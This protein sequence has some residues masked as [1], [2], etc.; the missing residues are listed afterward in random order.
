MYWTDTGNGTPCQKNGTEDKSFEKTRLSGGRDFNAVCPNCGRTRAILVDAE[1]CCT[2]CGAVLGTESLS[3]EA[4]PFSK[5]NL[6]QMESVGTAKVA[7]ECARHIHEQDRDM[8][9]MS[10]VCVKLDLPMYAAKDAYSTYA[11]VL[12]RTREDRAAF[13][14]SL[15]A[16]PAPPHGSPPATLERPKYFTK[17]H[18]AAFAIH[19]SCNRYALPRSDSAILAA[20]KS[21]FGAK[22]EFTILRAY[23]LVELTARDLGIGLVFDKSSY[24]LRLLLTRL[25]QEIGP[26]EAYD[27]VSV[28]AFENLLMILKGRDD[29]RARRAFEIAKRSVGLHVQV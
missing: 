18:V 14:R 11:K 19:L 26:C 3:G 23:S 10:S 17:A 24:H 25:Q 7:L 1:V 22:K 21:N 20:V 9:R 15:A 13:A 29:D 4:P 2:R 12:R 27:R 6:Y 28:L 16:F 8:S 5:L